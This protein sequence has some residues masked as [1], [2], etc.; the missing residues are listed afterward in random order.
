MRMA[1]SCAGDGAAGAVGVR[2]CAGPQPEG[3]AHADL[4]GLVRNLIGTSL[5]LPYIST[6]AL[7]SAASQCL[8]RVDPLST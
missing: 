3:D 2:L 5:S 1:K 4:A 6:I 7:Q 8:R